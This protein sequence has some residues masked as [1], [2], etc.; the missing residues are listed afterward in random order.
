M[1]KR[2][3]QR[4]SH[5]HLAELNDGK[6]QL[7]DGGVALVGVVLQEQLA[8]SR[9]IKAISSNCGSC[10]DMRYG[11]RFGLSTPGR[12]CPI[13]GLPCAEDAY[14]SQVTRGLVKPRGLVRVGDHGKPA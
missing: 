6:V 13:L 8:R 12:F 7:L 5:L 14:S 11:F 3:L 1:P 9:Q 10:A 2:P 4:R